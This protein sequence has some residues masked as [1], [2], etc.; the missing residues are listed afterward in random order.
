MNKV[1]NLEQ[2]EAIT[3]LKE[4]LKPGD[5]V[6]CILR[7]VSKSGMFRVIDLLKVN[8]PQNILGIGWNV[9][10]ALDMKYDRDREGIKVSGCGMDMG[11]SVVYDLSRT[12]YPNGHGCIGKSCPSNDHNNGDRDYTID[13]KTTLP[14]GEKGRHYHKDGGY[15]LK[16]RWL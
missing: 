7:H 14:S 8:D 4:W 11:F 6:H 15:A 12:L 9:A 3:R 10:K 13:R 2:A 5:T 16:H 1:S